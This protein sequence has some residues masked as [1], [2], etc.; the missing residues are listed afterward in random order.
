MM[1]HKWTKVLIFFLVVMLLSIEGC[2]N[3][4]P[5]DEKEQYIV[6][7]IEDFTAVKDYMTEQYSDELPVTVALYD[8]EIEDVPDYLSGSMKVVSED[9]PN[10]ESYGV[11]RRYYYMYLTEEYVV[12]WSDETLH[13]GLLYSENIR[14]AVKAA[15]KKYYDELQYHQLN[16]NWAWVGYNGL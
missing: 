4:G 3:N 14:S 6:D 16:D 2:G 8:I 10:I 5:R 9:D 15:R 7:H 11:G 1:I 13:D 12:F